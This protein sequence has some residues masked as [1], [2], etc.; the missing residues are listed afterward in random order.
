MNNT[1]NLSLHE[2]REGSLLSLWTVAKGGYRISN[3]LRYV[4]NPGPGTA[5]PFIVPNGRIRKVYPVLGNKLLHRNFAALDC[6]NE[7]DILKFAS[8][9][10]LLKKP[11]LL[12]PQPSGGMLTGESLSVWK[13]QNRKLGLLLAIWDMVKGKKVGKL[14]QFIIWSV[15]G[16]SVHLSYEGY[17]E[18][19]IASKHQNPELLKRWHRGDVIEPALYYI[20]RELNKNLDSQFSFKIL[21]FMNKEIYTMPTTL[22]S[23]M[24]LTFAREISGKVESA[25]C[26]MCTEWFER[27]HARDKF[28]SNACK[29]KDYRIRKGG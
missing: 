23:A 19:S 12:Y 11:L 15:S 1:E 10:G 26:P 7:G 24:W 20:C 8:K 17:G 4:G 14:G 16:D 28:C 9:Y 29:Q 27:D 13:S 22:E 25:Q 3:D 2:A 18:F 21:P 6:K 5:P